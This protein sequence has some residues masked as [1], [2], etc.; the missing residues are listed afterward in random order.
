MPTVTVEGNGAVSLQ[1][2][3]QA[4]G[5]KT[6]QAVVRSVEGIQVWQQSQLSLRTIDSRQA[7]VLNAPVA[8]FKAGNYTVSLSGV[9]DREPQEVGNYDFKLVKRAARR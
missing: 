4:A 1:L 3:L 8:R 6:Y 5:F 2:V 9:G 7:V